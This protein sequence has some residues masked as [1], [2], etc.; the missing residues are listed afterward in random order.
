MFVLFKFTRILHGA[1]VDPEVCR[2]DPG[3]NPYFS[4]H[5]A[6]GLYSTCVV[7]DGNILNF[8]Q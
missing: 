8:S 6:R 1:R 7:C 3:M 2:V 4:R 5:V